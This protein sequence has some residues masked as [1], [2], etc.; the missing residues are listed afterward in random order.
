[1]GL[2]IFQLFK[3]IQVGSVVVD[4]SVPIDTCI[5][6]KYVKELINGSVPIGQCPT[7]HLFKFKI[8]K[9]LVKSQSFFVITN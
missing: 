7:C 2:G 1:M 6:I 3:R 5:K 9:G 8:S 4:G